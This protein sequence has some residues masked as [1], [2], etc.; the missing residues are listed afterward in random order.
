MGYVKEAK[1]FAQV[2][3]GHDFLDLSSDIDPFVRGVRFYL[4]RFHYQ[5][6]ILSIYPTLS[7]GIIG[8]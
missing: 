4:K 5:L 1:A 2:G 7:Y 8:V 6:Y 3:L